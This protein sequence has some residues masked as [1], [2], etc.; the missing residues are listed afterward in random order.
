MTG[1]LE[2][3]LTNRRI[4][5]FPYHDDNRS[6]VIELNVPDVV[7]ENLGDVRPGVLPLA[8]SEIKAP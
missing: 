6:V 3:E 5:L 2:N 1:G 8:F 7:G 4:P